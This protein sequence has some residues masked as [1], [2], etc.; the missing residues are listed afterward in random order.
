MLFELL[1]VWSHSFINALVA[2]V[3]VTRDVVD[4]FGVLFLRCTTT[5]RKMLA[6][7]WHI[8]TMCV[9]YIRPRCVDNPATLCSPNTGRR[10]LAFAQDGLFALGLG[11]GSAS[12]HSE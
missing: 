1:A 7:L 3:I 10:W 2:A 4:C 12:V 6:G 8:H 11:G 9:L 5:G